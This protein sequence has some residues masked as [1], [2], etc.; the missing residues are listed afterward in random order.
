MILVD[1]F[2]IIN[3]AEYKLP[4]LKNRKDRPT[5]M[6]YGF[7]RLCEALERDLKDRLVLCWEG[8]NNFRKRI[9]SEYKANRRPT[10]TR[11]GSSR[12]DEFKQ[13]LRM[14]YANAV[15]PGFEADDVIASLVDKY[16]NKERII[17]WS[18]DKDLLQLIQENVIVIKD[19]MELNRSY[20]WNTKTVQQ[21]FNG[22]FPCELPIYY[23]LSGDACDNIPGAPRIRKP[24]LQQAIVNARYAENVIS[25]IVDFE[26]WSAKELQSLEQFVAAGYFQR[27]LELIILRRPDV[28]IEESVYDKEKIKEW[29]IMMDFRSLRLS[30]N[31]GMIDEEAEF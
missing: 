19:Y 5:G 6:E 8:G 16:K 13:F 20:K 1:A 22:L 14:V 18:N 3:R 24:T 31:V 2:L 17:I 25:A 9:Y 21:K 27:N 4:F 7:L 15:A 30:D 10:G 11:I 29:L 26:L 12:I 28:I 23:A